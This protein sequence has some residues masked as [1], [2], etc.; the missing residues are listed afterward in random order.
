MLRCCAAVNPATNSNTVIHRKPFLTFYLETDSQDSQPH[1][2][3]PRREFFS[4]FFVVMF[5][6]LLAGRALRRISG[7]FN[8]DYDFFSA[9][10]SSR[11]WKASAASLAA[12]SG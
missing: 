8:C 5:A 12:L 3:K 9:C 7:M 6:P 2:I 4:A 11:C 1:I 10:P